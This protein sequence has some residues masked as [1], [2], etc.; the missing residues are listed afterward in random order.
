MTCLGSRRFCEY[1]D[2]RWEG[3]GLLRRWL[4]ISALLGGVLGIALIDRDAGVQSW[5]HLRAD[6]TQSRTRIQTLEREVERLQTEV[7]ALRS[8]PFAVERAI[9][10]ELGFARSGELVVRLRPAPTP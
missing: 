7:K 4:L 2:F 8:S 5:L 6:L 9:R 3:W 10:E 1:R